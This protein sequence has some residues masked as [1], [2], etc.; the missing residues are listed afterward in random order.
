MWNTDWAW[1][2]QKT[3]N[4]S[5]SR[6]YLVKSIVWV[7]WG[8]LVLLQDSTIACLYTDDLTHW[9]RVTHICVGKL[10]IIGSD[11]G[12]LPGRRQAIIR[13]NVGILL[14]GTL[15]TNFSEILCEIHTFLFMKMHLKMTSGIWQPFCLCLN[16]LKLDHGISGFRF[17]YLWCKT[18][19]SPV[20]THR[21][22]NRLKVSH[23]Y[24]IP[25]QVWGRL[26]YRRPDT[27][28]SSM[29]TSSAGSS[30]GSQCHTHCRTTN[31]KCWW[32]GE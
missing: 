2:S 13:T 8:K 12:L 23:Q 18:V 11:N 27:T 7:F 29:T 5:L 28:P 22:N 3:L 25:E 1:N 14:I 32:G 15:G 20:L 24:N 10:T 19:V 17:Q 4:I 9:G 31:R 30:R 21:R 6:V 16:V 26:C